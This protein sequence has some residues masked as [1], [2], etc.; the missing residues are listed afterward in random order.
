M[1]PTSALT[2]PASGPIAPSAAPVVSGAPDQSG[3]EL[4]DYLAVLR[5]RKGLVVLAAFVVVVTAL[6]ASL[7]Q[8]EVYEGRADVLLQSRRGETLF[9][10][11][12]GRVVSPTR[13]IDTEIQVMKSAP[14]RQRVA[15]QLGRVPDVSVSS[16]GDA[17]V[18]AVRARHTDPASAAAIAN[19][20]A[21]SYIDYK[22]QRTIDDLLAA[23]S[24]I[25][26]KITEIQ[27]DIDALND[28]VTRAAPSERASVETSVAPRR[29]SFL[30]QQAAFRQTLD[31]LQV[32]AALSSGGAQIV[33]PAEVPSSPVEPRPMRTMVVAMIIG[34][35]F[36]V[37]IALLTDYLDDSVREKRDL[38]VASGGLTVVGLIPAFTDRKSREG[39]LVADFAT[40]PTEAYRTLR[41]SI[42]FMCLDQPRRILQVTSSSAAEG[43]TTTLANLGIALAN[44]GSRVALVDFDLRRP[45]LHE[46]FR[47]DNEIG[48]TTLLL[49]RNN[50]DQALRTV[51]E[52]RG[53]LRVLS[54]GP[55]PPNPS[56]LLFSPR[57]AK[58]LEA[59]AEQVDIVLV[60]S[61]PVL[62]VTDAQIVSRNVDGLLFVA[63]AG[64][65]TK[66]GLARA[67]EL[68]RQVDAPLIGTVL[69]RAEPN[70]SYGYG[71]GYGGYGTY[72]TNTTSATGAATSAAE[73]S[74]RG[75]HAVAQARS[76]VRAATRRRA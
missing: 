3:G 50:L 20:F 37:A 2:P 43:K 60:D 5:R 26:T 70:D 63:A 39:P 27:A 14:V 42:Q 66:R 44:A 57:M 36:G 46:V 62:P 68:L 30:N 71:Y 74:E 69:N 10:P 17:D 22:R 75:L 34:L 15:E 23:T 59:V 76:M 24:Q 31:Q 35:M 13:T 12:S 11:T 32:N 16:V 25:Q 7:L 64:T 67:V 1:G 4:R 49:G 40:P 55:I 18:M 48:F 19:A 61:P 6:V 8:T 73:A 51:P 38:E 72:G 28:Q 54:S 41:T 21:E 58:V 52:V 29:N 45:R 65:T 56:E 47:L 9:D 33:T 53:H